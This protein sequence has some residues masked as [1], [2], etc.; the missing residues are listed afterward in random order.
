CGKEVENTKA[1][2]SHIHYVHGTENSEST[3]DQR[4]RSDSEKERFQ[5][6]LDSCVSTR[7]LRTPREAE[8]IEQAIREIPEGISPA[9]DQYRDAFSCALQNEKLL[10]EVEEELVQESKGDKA[11]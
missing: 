11:K 10:K 8:K 4:P 3:Y 7:G 1:L 2:G 6:L 9:L 5:R